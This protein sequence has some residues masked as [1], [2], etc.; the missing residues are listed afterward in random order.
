MSDIDTT[1][2]QII[3]QNLTHRATDIELHNAKLENRLVNMKN[4]ESALNDLGKMFIDKVKKYRDNPN[5][6]P[7][8]APKKP[9]YGK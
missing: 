7:L 4:I 5:S 9:F 3:L 8:S 6:I 2:F 1:G